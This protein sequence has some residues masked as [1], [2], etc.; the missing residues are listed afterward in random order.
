MV[1]ERLG[2]AETSLW[3]FAGDWARFGARGIESVPPERSTRR[4]ANFGIW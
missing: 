1:Y 4:T 2:D 3:N